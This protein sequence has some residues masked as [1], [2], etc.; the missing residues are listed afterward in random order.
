MKTP[1]ARDFDEYVACFAQDVQDR[2]RQVRDAIQKA[3][4]RGTPA[5]SYGMPAFRSGDAVVWFAASARHIGFYPGAAAIKRFAKELSSYSCAKGSVRFPFT[6]PLPL[7]LIA[8]MA[9]FR[10]DD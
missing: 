6:E 7:A 4:P 8:R 10:L 5:I 9:K 2:L 3:A 1:T